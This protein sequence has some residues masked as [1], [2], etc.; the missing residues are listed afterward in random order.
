LGTLQLILVQNKTSH[1]GNSSFYSSLFEMSLQQCITRKAC[2]F[3]H[4]KLTRKQV[5]VDDVVIVA[6]VDSVS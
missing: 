2:Y 1:T 6:E 4:A 5:L 3:Q